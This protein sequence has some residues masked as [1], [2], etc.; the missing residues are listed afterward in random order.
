MTTQA[1]AQP[2]CY[3]GD[4]L[5]L[6]QLLSS[7]M[8]ESERRGQP[9]HDEMLFIVVHQAYELWFKQILHELDRI[10][11]ISRARLG[12][13]AHLGTRSCTASSASTRS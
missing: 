7:Q 2:P 4:Y 1:D 13:R 5:R 3:Y 8:R 6:D 10:R 11:R 12:G 9:A